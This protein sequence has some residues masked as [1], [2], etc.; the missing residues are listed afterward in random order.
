MYHV[1][2]SIPLLLV[3]NFC[4]VSP[5]SH[6]GGPAGS[7]QR[8]PVEATQNETVR[9]KVYYNDEKTDVAK[10][11]AVLKKVKAI[12]DIND[13]VIAVTQE[14]T[15]TP[16]VGGTL[17]IPHEEQLYVNTSGVDCSTFVETVISLAKTA[18][19]DKA[20]I[21]S[22]LENLQSLRYGKGKIDGFPSRLHYISEWVIDNSSRGNLKEI[23]GD[24]PFSETRV[25]TLDFMTKNRNLYPAMADDEVYEA[26]K[27]NER[28][29]KNL[30]YSIIPTSRVNDAGKSFLRSGDIVAIETTKPGL[31][32][33][34]VGVIRIIKGVPYL[35]HASSKFKKVINDTLPLQEYLKKQRSPGIR[36]FRL[37]QG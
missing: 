4:S 24:Y 14:F 19:S 10:I 36:V 26:V 17:N 22:Y 20:G 6:T 34:H 30:N 18:G 3:L 5:A 15:G 9:K 29:L 28:A 7:E 33:S 13:R 37:P 31:D 16:Y 25:K 27:E 32:V 12:P 35:I 11:E 1:F 2:T 8:E 21:N 23:S